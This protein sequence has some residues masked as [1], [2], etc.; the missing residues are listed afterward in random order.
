V[1]ASFPTVEPALGLPHLSL[2]QPLLM[3]RDETGEGHP[4]ARTGGYVF[5]HILVMDDM[6]QRDLLEG[7]SVHDRDGVRD[8]HRPGNLEPWI[9]ARPP[10]IRAEDAV[11]WAKEILVRY[12]GVP[13][14]LQQ[15]FPC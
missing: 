2:A 6:L 14:H 8:D 9:R 11:G 10:G 12:E 4:R 1:S 3:R 5:E 7:E 15:R 13:I